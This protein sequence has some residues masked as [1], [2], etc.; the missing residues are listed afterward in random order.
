[1]IMIKQGRV[2]ECV[3]AYLTSFQLRVLKYTY[4]EFPSAL[5]QTNSPNQR[6]DDF[7]RDCR[8]CFSFSALLLVFGIPRTETARAL[9]Q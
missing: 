4:S 8:F 2:L 1:M 7:L 3:S 6:Y 5:S 9:L